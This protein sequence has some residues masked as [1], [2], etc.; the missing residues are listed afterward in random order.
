MVLPVA[1]AEKVT[2]PV[3][4][5]TIP[6]ASN[7]FPE[8]SRVVLPEN[9]PA[10]PVKSNPVHEMFV[11]VTVPVPAETLIEPVLI[12]EQVIV[13]VV[14]EE[15]VKSTIAVL[16]L[17]V[18]FVALRVDHTVPVPVLVQVPVPILI[19]LDVEPVKS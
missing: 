16:G 19:V 3:K 1:V 5:L 14:P 4:L 6:V 9:V 8:Q 7:K 15:L 17:S 2:A 11:H 10:K 13:L 18:I 12:D